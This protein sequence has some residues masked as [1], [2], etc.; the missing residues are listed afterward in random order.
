MPKKADRITA[1]VRTALQLCRAA[2]SLTVALAAAAVLSAA[3][4]DNC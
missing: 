3:A 2:L 1:A 4:V